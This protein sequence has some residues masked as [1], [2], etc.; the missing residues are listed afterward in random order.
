MWKNIEK[1][2]GIPKYEGQCWIALRFL[3]LDLRN[4]CQYEINNFRK[5]HFLKVKYDTVLT[6]IKA[7]PSNCKNISKN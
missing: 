3:L 1:V 6:D 2:P 7:N 5:E 4:H